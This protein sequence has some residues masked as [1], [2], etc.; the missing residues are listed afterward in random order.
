MIRLRRSA[1]YVPASNLRALDKA[2][3]LPAD[4]VIVDLEDAVA[5]HD[6]DA[7]RRNLARLGKFPGET[8]VRIN[9][10]DT[11]WHGADIEAV[12]ALRPNA[13]VLPK[14]LSAADVERCGERTDI[15]IWPMMETARAVLAA[16]PIA[17]AAAKTGPS[18]LI[19]GTND[20]AAELRVDLSADRA[21][22]SDALS[23]CVLAARAAG[24]DII[25]GVTNDVRDDARLE[26]EVEEGV[27]IGM[28]GK[29]VIHPRQIPIVNQAFSPDAGAV[30]A[31]KRVKDA[32]TAA[33]GGVAVL[34]GRMVE[35]L[36]ARAAERTLA[37]AEAIAWRAKA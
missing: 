3:T 37:M 2:R 8:A 29:S 26:A 15:T 35:A 24:V 25:D 10:A 28:D 5:P 17:C 6:K 1:L 13:V 4:V 7:A 30:A 32:V 20:L 23:G 11:P 36:H 12:I 16:Y 19:M 33:G 22:M 27:R 31:A 21:P 34:D 18:A 9:A 14:V